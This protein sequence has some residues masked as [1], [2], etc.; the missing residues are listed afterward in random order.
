MSP[1]TTTVIAVVVSITIVLIVVIVAVFLWKRARS[2]SLKFDYSGS[3]QL[4]PGYFQVQERHWLADWPDFEKFQFDRNKIEKIREL[5]EGEFGKVYLASADGIVPGEEKTQ[6]A[7]KTM[8]KDS[9]RETA[10]DF[11]KE[12]DIMM[13]FDHPNIVKLLGVCTKEEPLYIITELMSK[14]ILRSTVSI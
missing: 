9:S 3:T 6:V 2:G 14:V 12:M 8:K 10:E 1:D 13:E 4:G 11:R 7:L 5:G